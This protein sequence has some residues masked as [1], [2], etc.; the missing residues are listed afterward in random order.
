MS[1]CG[2]EPLRPIFGFVCFCIKCLLNVAAAWNLHDK[3]TALW[4][5]GEVSIFRT[6]LTEIQG[7]YI[8]I[9][10]QPFQYQ[11]FFHVF[12]LENS[13]SVGQLGPPGL[14]L[15][16]LHQTA[17]PSQLGQAAQ[18]A[19]QP[20]PVLEARAQTPEVR[21]HRCM[22]ISDAHTHRHTHRERERDVNI[23]IYYTYV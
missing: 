10:L 23:Y 20:P 6:I 7:I 16:G 4:L 21:C 8:S 22:A 11:W 17:L 13:L 5:P 15:L 12:S 19:V 14:W 3:G 9:V 1:D 18:V 2:G